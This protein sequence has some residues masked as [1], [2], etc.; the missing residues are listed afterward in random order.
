V[1]LSVVRISVVGLLVVGLAV[2]GLAVVGFAVMGLAVVGLAVVGL[3]VVGLAVVGLAVVGLAFMGLTVVGFSAV[4][5]GFHL[6]SP[7]SYWNDPPLHRPLS[8]SARELPL[9]ISTLRSSSDDDDNDVELDPP[10]R[11]IH[12]I[13]P[14]QD[15][16]FLSVL[17]TRTC[18]GTFGGLLMIMYPA[19]SS[20][21]T[22]MP[23]LL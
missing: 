21:F 12:S 17:S 2:V 3:A 10:H 19:S 11:S 1:G 4:R 7:K 15:A 13:L 6:S 16:T 14:M 23:G 9:S 18:T 8:S 20:R 5:K 22:I